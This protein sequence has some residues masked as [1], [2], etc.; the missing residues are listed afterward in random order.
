MHEISFEKF[1]HEFAPKNPTRFKISSKCLLVLP[2]LR[3]RVALDP[4]IGN[5]FLLRLLVFWIDRVYLPPPPPE[6]GGRLPRRNF[7]IELPPSILRLIVVFVSKVRDDD[8][9][10]E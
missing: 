9:S 1:V 7:V 4:T 10:C 3:R 2:L 6:G 8:N 5:S